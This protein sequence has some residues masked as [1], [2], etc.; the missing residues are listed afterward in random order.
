MKGIVFFVVLALSSI[1]HSAESYLIMPIDAITDGDTIK[2]HFSESRLP[3]PLNQVSIRIRGLDSPEYPSKYFLE[4]GK[5]GKADCVEE[6]FAAISS[7]NALVSLI[8]ETKTMKITNFDWDKFGGRIDA[9]VKI[10]GKD[11]GTFLLS[12]GFAI[13]Y[14][15]HRKKNA[16]CE[17][18]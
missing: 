16:W 1:V 8:G 14:D 4:S 11:L 3:S 5:L 13:P 15:G 7:R 9:D 2:T 6:A 12:K 17:K 10:N 18:L